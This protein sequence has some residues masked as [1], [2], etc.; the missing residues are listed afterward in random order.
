MESSLALPTAV[1][2]STVTGQDVMGFTMV[3]PLVIKHCLENPRNKWKLWPVMASYGNGKS[4]NRR[5][6]PASHV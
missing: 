4:S 3:Y 5:D 2:I 6:F 1:A